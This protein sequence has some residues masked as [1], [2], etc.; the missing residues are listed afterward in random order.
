[1]HYVEWMNKNISHLLSQRD[2]RP[3]HSH[4][5]K[6]GAINSL[7]S[8]ICMGEYSVAKRDLNTL[9]C[10]KKKKKV[11]QSSHFSKVL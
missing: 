8:C 7:Q 9:I 10:K 3:C 11:L 4:R 1:M 5:F 2:R 6:M